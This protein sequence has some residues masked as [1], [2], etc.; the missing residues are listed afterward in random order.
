MKIIKERLQKL[1]EEMASQ[2]IDCY[3]VTGTD[4][5]QS[6]YVAEHWNVRGWLSGFTGSAGQLV[7]T[8]DFAALWTDSRYFLQAAEELEDTGIIL[9]KQKVQYAPE[10]LQWI[11]DNMPQGS[12]VMIDGLTMSAYSFQEASN[13]YLNGMNIITQDTLLNTVWRDRST[14]PTSTVYILS[15]KYVGVSSHQKIQDIRQWL[16]EHKL[17]GLLLTA[18]DDI[19]WVT[20]L[21]GSDVM[22]NPVNM[23][24]LY[25]SIDRVALFVD[26]KKIVKDVMSYL[27]ELTVE[28]ADYH[29]IFEYFQ[30]VC[31]ADLVGI[32][33]YQTN[34]TL[35]SAINTPVSISNPVTLSKGKKNDTEVLNIKCAMVSDGIALTKAF[36]WLEEQLTKRSVSEY[37]FGTILT[38]YRKEDPEYLQDSFGAIVGYNSNGAIIHYSAQKDK[39]A[40]IKPEGVLLVDSGGQYLTGTTDITRTV[41]V[42]A[43]KDPIK[44]S[45]TLVLKGLISLTEVTFPMGTTGVQ[46]DILA[47]QHLWH[48]GKSYSHGT[49]HGVGFCLNVH[50]GPQGFG[51]LNSSKSKVAF[52]EGMVTSN[53]PGYYV[54][55]QY[56][57]RIENLILTQKHS[58]HENYLCFETLTLFP[59]DTSLIDTSLLTEQEVNWINSYHQAV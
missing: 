55:G 24:Y 28:I 5:H 9:M 29:A 36:Y 39:S 3:V 12:R 25:I 43:V 2:N 32:D 26:R 20:N 10:H 57:I 47:R 19:A 18:L 42:G 22:Y 27:N 6:E 49:G 37:E 59:I 33:S 56:G 8:L 7:I 51:G 21:R 15:E 23:A 17:D 13:T 30:K 14:L 48:Y 4:P 40:E 50:E 53:E 35:A 34:H 38:Q 1:R 31:P 54:D 16:K 52:E 44:E 41:A 11:K 45:F 58:V 46:M